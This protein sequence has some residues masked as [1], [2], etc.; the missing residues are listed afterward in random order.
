M[1]L[2]AGG[3][4]FQPLDQ[5]VIEARPA[6]LPAFSSTLTTLGPFHLSPSPY[7]CLCLCP[8]LAAM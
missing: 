7:P 4:H 3:R 1:R 6:Q 8:S 5:D 2:T